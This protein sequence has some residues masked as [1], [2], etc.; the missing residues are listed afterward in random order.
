MRKELW[1]YST[2]ENF[3][4]AELI[5]ESYQ[6]IRPAPGYPA[7]P[8]HTEKQLLFNLLDVTGQTG[9]SLTENYAM[10]PT[11]AVSGYYFSH[12]DS[13]YFGLGNVSKEQVQDYA[14][15]KEM[16]I[17]EMERWLAPNLGYAD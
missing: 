6:G 17:K 1:G 10:L 14:K 7:C 5:K 13:L 2:D 16:D 11:A 8:D 9:I 4:N 3:S 12:P 15:R